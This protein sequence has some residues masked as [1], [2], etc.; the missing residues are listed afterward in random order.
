[1]KSFKKAFKTGAILLL[2][3]LLVAACG[4]NGN[5]ANTGGSS[6]TG[7][8]G[9]GGSS[10]SSGTSNEPV[11]LTFMTWGY[12]NY[13]NAFDAWIAGLKEKYNITIDMQNVPNDSYQTT[14]KT[15]YASN[16]LPDLFATHSI[17]RNLNLLEK[18]T[19]GP[20]E[21]VDLSD[22][23]SVQDYLPSVIEARKNNIAGKLFY[24]P[25][26]INVLGVLYN[27]KVFA[28]HGLE[29]PTNI[30]E[31]VEL[32]EKLKAAGV[33]PL[34]S[35][36]KESWT[37]QIIPFIAFGQ[38]VN[39]KYPTAKEELATGELKYA[40]IREDVVKAL[41]VQLDWLDKGYFGDN[42]LGTD[43]TAAAQM[44]ANG[45]AAMMVSGN[46][47]YSQVMN[48]NPDAEI[49][50]FPLPLN[51]PGEPTVLPTNADEGI[52]IKSSTKHLDAALQAMD[53]YLSVE[54]QTLIANEFNGIPTNMK[55][56]VENPFVK[57]IQAAFEQTEVQPDWWGTSGLY[58][59]LETTFDLGKEHQNLVAKGITPDE[60]IDQFDAANAR[61][62]GK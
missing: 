40:D 45:D 34:A 59:P 57:E 20:D 26:S 28:Q 33:I 15:R 16:D 54:I 55:V 9:T 3:I 31:F 44:L 25:V 18:L 32:A 30:D 10:G 49:G 56:Q 42:Y 6:G 2:A 43:S 61:A 47:M 1:M 37:T 12:Q 8:T 58:Y 35:G 51:A 52:V 13:P 24:V 62:L 36:F 17:D 48:A 19:V 14:L 5:V 53:Y 22:L 38:Y 23:P 60:F 29:I 11:T 39:T 21:L 7:S 41:N 46:W 4:S 50:F 27:K